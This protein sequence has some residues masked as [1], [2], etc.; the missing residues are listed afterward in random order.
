MVANVLKY[1]SDNLIILYYYVYSRLLSTIETV[2]WNSIGLMRNVGLGPWI[3]GWL[4]W[5]VIHTRR[6]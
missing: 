5:S 6:K 2:I 3:N 4:E 1:K